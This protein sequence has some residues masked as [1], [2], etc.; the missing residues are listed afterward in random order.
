KRGR[1]IGFPTANLEVTG[2]MIPRHGV[3]AGWLTVIDGAC[4]DGVATPVG[5]R[6]P[7]AVSLGHNYTVGGIDLR[8]EAHVIGRDDL[9]LYGT[10]VTLDLV[11]WSRPMLDFGSL[12]A[13]TV[14]LEEDVAWCRTA[15]GLS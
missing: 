7:A 9:A 5:E 11:A 14:A 2:G 10:T 8:V 1:I 13:L 4:R 12:E 3:Y 15:L 6:L